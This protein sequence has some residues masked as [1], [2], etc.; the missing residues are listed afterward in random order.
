M[1]GTAAFPFRNSSARLAL[2]LCQALWHLARDAHVRCVKRSVLLGE[3]AELA[4]IHSD[5]AS[6]AKVEPKGESNAK[7]ARRSCHL[8]GSEHGNPHSRISTG[9]GWLR[10]LNGLAVRP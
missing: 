1:L 4:F 10:K 3:S 9:G 8:N 2:E 6:D 5:Q 7:T